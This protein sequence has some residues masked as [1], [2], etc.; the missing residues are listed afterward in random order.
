MLV[1]L[2]WYVMEVSTMFLWLGVDALFA[3]TVKI[4]LFDDILMFR[5]IDQA[6]YELILRPL[7]M[8]YIGN[9]LNQI[10]SQ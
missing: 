9:H 7:E 6:T 2:M 1:S 4:L 3:F 5:Y 8:I 10:L